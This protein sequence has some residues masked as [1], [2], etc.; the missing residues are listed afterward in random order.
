MSCGEN[1]YLL[2]SF[3]RGLTKVDDILPSVCEELFAKTLKVAVY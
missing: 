1:P 2:C 3:L